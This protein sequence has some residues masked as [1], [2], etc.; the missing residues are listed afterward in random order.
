MSFNF[1]FPGDKNEQD[2]PGGFKPR[3]LSMKA[4]V[5]DSVYPLE[6]IRQATTRMEP[7]LQF[8][9]IILTMPR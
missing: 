6:N 3:S 1:L 5:I 7:R 8:G 2:P 9:K 4:A